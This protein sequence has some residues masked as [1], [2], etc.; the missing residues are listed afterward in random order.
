MEIRLSKMKLWK[1]N[2]SSSNSRKKNYS[3][4]GPL[5]VLFWKPLDYCLFS[6]VSIDYGT[7]TYEKERK[8]LGFG[9]F[10]FAGTSSCKDKKTQYDVTRPPSWMW[11]W[12]QRNEICHT[13]LAFI[14]VIFSADSVSAT[15]FSKCTPN[16]PSTLVTASLVSWMANRTV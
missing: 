12:P 1:R 6:R 16:G 11:A 15:Y 4:T 9:R 8:P 2:F 7:N 13:F 5:G 14:A 10:V 3:F